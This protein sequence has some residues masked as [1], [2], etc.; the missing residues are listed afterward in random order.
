MLSCCCHRLPFL[1]RRTCP[2]LPLPR[3][4]RLSAVRQCPAIQQLLGSAK[5]SQ[6]PFVVV[7]RSAQQ[8]A[9]VV[10]GLNAAQPLLAGAP[11]AAVAPPPRVLR[12]QAGRKLHPAQ[13]GQRRVAQHAGC[14][15]PVALE[16]N[17]AL[18]GGA[19]PHHVCLRPLGK[20]H[21]CGSRIVSW[22]LHGEDV[23]PLLRAVVAME[24]RVGRRKQCRVQ[25]CAASVSLAVL[26]NVKTEVV[27]A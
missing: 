24:R 15:L 5:V 25:R 26:D 14:L 27:A 6:Q 10:D 18:K 17:H 3:S 4:C 2:L 19:L 12:P 1:W 7:A 8:P 13:A 11:E 21:N 22:Q 20:Q 16:H 9:A 23:L